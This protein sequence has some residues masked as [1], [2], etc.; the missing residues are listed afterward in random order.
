MINSVQ[1]ANFAPKAL[2]QV[3]NKSE[4]RQ[5]FG[6]SNDEFVSQ[7]NKKEESF[8]KKHWGKL[9]VAG[10]LI[11]GAIFA[12]KKGYFKSAEESVSKASKESPKPDDAKNA[13][14]SLPEIPQ[15]PLP[16]HMIHRN[17]GMQNHLD[18]KDNEAI[19]DFT[20]AIKAAPEEVENYKLRAI[21]YTSLGEDEKAI[22]DYTTAIKKGLA[23]TKEQSNLYLYR[24]DLFS[25]NDPDKALV[26]YK[27]A[28]SIYRGNYMANYNTGI[29]LFNKKEYIEA[30]KY[31]KDAAKHM[32]NNNPD[33]YMILSDIY[34]KMGD[35]DKAAE[36]GRM[37]IEAG[38]HLKVYVG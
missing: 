1:Q 28:A 12:H 6:Q 17:N 36:F 19:E 24:G 5:S 13:A 26:D 3:R 10:A 38:G 23:D 37:Y 34:F 8:L 7:Q 14:K 18:G 4:S 15:E 20:R 30:E 31:A 21:S 11:A 29:L 35:K 33:A 22:A 2:N 9:L 27:T 25:K 32:P 16:E